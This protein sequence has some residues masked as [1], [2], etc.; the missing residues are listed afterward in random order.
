MNPLHRTANVHA[1]PQVR[2]PHAL[3]LMA[4]A[5]RRPRGFSLVMVLIVMVVVSLIGVAASQV[6]LLGERS[7]RF[8]RDWQIAYQAAEAALMDAEFDIRGPNTHTAQRMAQFANDSREGFIDGCGTSG[9]F[10]G[11]CKSVG[12][13]AQAAFYNVNFTDTGANAPS[14]RFGEF[15]GRVMASSTGIGQGTQPEL[16]PRYIIEDIPDQP[17]G[18]SAATKKVMYRVT[19]VGFGP[20]KETQAVLQMFFRKE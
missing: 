5:A 12:S 20:R 13:G 15:T 17:P 4:P 9:S 2:H 7:A 1:G 10:R 8:D 11:L 18:T 6:A 14:A 3:R 19:A 16:L